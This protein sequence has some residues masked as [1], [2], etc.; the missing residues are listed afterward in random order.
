MTINPLF[1][2]K[3]DL[4]GNPGE[5]YDIGCNNNN[6]NCLSETFIKLNFTETFEKLD[7]CYKYKLKFV[8]VVD[9]DIYDKN[10]YFKIF[11]NLEKGILKDEFKN[12]K[13]YRRTYLTNEISE[14]CIKNSEYLTE[15]KCCTFHISLYL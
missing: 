7:Q 14:V 6:N 11:D 8:Y 13:I 12:K 1:K 5:Y 10:K 4:N 9:D 2:S 15:Y 3:I